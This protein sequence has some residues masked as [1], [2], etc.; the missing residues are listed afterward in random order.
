MEQIEIG[1][2]YSVEVVKTLPYGLIV[3]LEDR[4]TQ[5]IHISNISDKFVR[6]VRDYA[7]VG[8]H[9]I[10]CGVPGNARDVELSLRYLNLEPKYEDLDDELTEEN[11]ATN[12][13]RMLEESLH[14][15][16]AREK[17]VFDGREKSR[18]PRSK[19]KKRSQRR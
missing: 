6:D 10:A 18:R 12:F 4:S 17:C 13:E 7:R 16:E 15:P 19:S 1:S 8:D 5:L 14:S 9:F 2:K 11:F 3:K